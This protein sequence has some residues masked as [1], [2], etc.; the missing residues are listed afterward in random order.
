[1]CTGAAA[2]SRAGGIPQFHDV[3]ITIV[4]NGGGIPADLATHIYEPF[5]TTKGERGTGLGLWAT[6]GIVD[7]LGGSVRV[8]SRVGQKQNVLVFQFSFPIRLRIRFSF[9]LFDCDGAR[10]NLSSCFEIPFSANLIHCR[11]NRFRT[12]RLK[13]KPDSTQRESGLALP[14]Q[15]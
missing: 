8:R 12:P 13:A 11:D 3:R 2:T 1:M 5:F 4:D 10:A 7:R 9:P 15:G 14:T 6:Q